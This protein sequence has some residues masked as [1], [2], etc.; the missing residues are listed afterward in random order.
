[1]ALVVSILLAPPPDRKGVG[2]GGGGLGPLADQ[3]NV[4]TLTPARFSGP[5]K[6]ARS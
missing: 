5:T 2:Q 1:M 6:E 3:A 4:R